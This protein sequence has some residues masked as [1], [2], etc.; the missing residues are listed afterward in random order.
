MSTH[1][2][3]DLGATSGRVSVGDIRD[4]S[5]H[6]VEVTRF[7]NDPL[8]VEGVPYWDTA[9]LFSQSVAGM[10]SACHLSQDM[11]RPATSI[12]IDSWG[13]D[14]GIVREEKRQMVPARHYRGAVPE[15]LS[16]VHEIVPAAV[17][18]RRTGTEQLPINSVYQLA[19]AS[20]RGELQ[21]DDCILPIPDLWTYCLTG[22]RGTELSIASTT[23]LL[24][25]ETRRWAADMAE[26]IGIPRTVLPDLAT[27]GSSAGNLTAELQ[28]EMGAERPI[29][30]V[31]VAE[32]DTASA[33]LALPVERNFAF[34][35]CGSWALVGQE[36]PS[37]V[38]DERARLSGFTNEV[39]AFGSTLFMRNLSGLWLLEECIREW[40]ATRNSPL[41]LSRLLEDASRAAGLRSVI[42]VGNPAFLRPGQL[43]ERI[44]RHCLDSGQPA[45]DSPAEV[46]RCVID[47]LALAY[48]VTIEESEHI[49]ARAAEVVH[50]IGGGSRNSLLCQLTAE[51]CQRPVFAGPAEATSLGNILAQGI[52]AGELEGVQHA[53]AVVRASFSS[54]QYTPS[55]ERSTARRWREAAFKLREANHLRGDVSE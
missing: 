30:I 5:V 19:A 25:V 13:V 55:G 3:V 49:S 7:K 34:I 11:G 48:R 50:L 24:D 1:I 14:F 8:D 17:A 21:P 46:V 45:P 38:V 43:S 42:D 44:A 52:A 39:G 27:T 10:R 18:Y 2:A 22:T 41:V 40:N 12:G 32:H 35:S 36:T 16:R 20:D 33:I 31:R 29:E 6:L 4:D 47:S 37:S 51:S 15:M 53:R 23:G 26:T 28:L 9:R 54:V